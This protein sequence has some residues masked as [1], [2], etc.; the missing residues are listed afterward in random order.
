MRRLDLI[1]RNR[2]R[3]GLLLNIALAFV[4]LAVIGAS[5]GWMGVTL[6]KK[7]A[8]LRTLED[9]IVQLQNQ[10]TELEVKTG[11]FLSAGWMA[12]QM[13]AHQIQL[14]LIQPQEVIVLGPSS[15]SPPPETP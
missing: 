2:L 13:E 10:I 7:Q 12:K 1:Y 4:I 11:A 14:R 9:D 8:S 15:G 3:P 5:H 6:Q